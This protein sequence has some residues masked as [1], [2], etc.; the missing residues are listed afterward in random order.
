[1]NGMLTTAYVIPTTSSAGSYTVPA[2]YIFVLFGVSST[3]NNAA[4]TIQLGGVQVYNGQGNNPPTSNL[5]S[6][7]PFMNP[8]F[9]DA[10]QTITF[11]G[12]G[13]IGWNGYLIPR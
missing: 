8:M 3:V 2:I 9:F 12:S 6:T 13:T 5:G 4:V 10:G 1:M 11:S 7:T